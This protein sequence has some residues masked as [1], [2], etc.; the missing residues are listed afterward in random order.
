[1]GQGVVG[2]QHTHSS[3]SVLSLHKPNNKRRVTLAVLRENYYMDILYSV[4]QNMTVVLSDLGL[5][6]EGK[7]TETRS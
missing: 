7:F 3:S 5:Y 4:V 2:Q 6:A 1:V